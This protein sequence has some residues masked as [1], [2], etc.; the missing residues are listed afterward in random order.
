MDRRAEVDLN[1]AM[2]G[3]GEFV[4]VQGTAEARGFSRK[5]LDELLRLAAKGIRQL[6]DVQKRALKRLP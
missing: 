6:M 5:Q 3:R 2:N 1:V 4:E